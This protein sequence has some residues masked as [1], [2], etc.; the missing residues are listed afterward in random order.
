VAQQNQAP[1]NDAAEVQ[2]YISFSQQCE[3]LLTIYDAQG[4]SLCDVRIAGEHTKN[5]SEVLR[6]QIQFRSQIPKVTAPLARID[7]EPFG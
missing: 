4:F 1:S 5:S 6:F 2:E 7:F 3:F